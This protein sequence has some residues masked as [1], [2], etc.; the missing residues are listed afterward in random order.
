MTSIMTRAEQSVE[1]APS[2]DPVEAAL[3]VSAT[4]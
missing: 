2:G 3:R 4:R 1:V